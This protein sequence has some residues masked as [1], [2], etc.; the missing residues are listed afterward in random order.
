MKVFLLAGE[1]SGD[2]LGA[3]L[4]AGL[5]KHMP[6]RPE[7]YGVGGPLM[8]QAGLKTL[9]PMSDI[10]LMG[11]S[12]I[13]SKYRFLKKRIAEAADA[14]I[15]DEA[16]VLITIDLPE[17]SLRLAKAVR[18]RKQVPSVHYVAP[19]VWAW[20]PGRAQKMAPFVDHVLALFPFEPPYMQA[21]GMSC[22]FVGHPVVN[23]PCATRGEAQ[24]FRAETGIDDAPMILC[25]PGSR[26]SEI[27][28]LAP[29]F[30]KVVE[31]LHAAR[32]DLKFVLPMAASVVTLVKDQI[33][34]WPVKPFLIEPRSD[35]HAY[36]QKRAA[37]Q[38]ADVALA[39]SGTVA[40]E[41]AATQTPMVVAYDMGFLSRQ[42]IGR[43]LKVETVSLVNLIT[44]SKSIPEFIAENCREELITPSVLKVL[45]DPTGQ[46]QAMQST[47]Q[48][49]GQNGHPPGE[50]AA[51]SVIKFLAAQ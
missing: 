39:A 32:P 7:F 18:R 46:I 36:S 30:A 33:A 42:I 31:K 29:V 8:E 1:A 43:M 49:L 37:F 38:A 13:L 51:Q 44:D 41:L 35:V 25:L 28:R 16:D 45:D 2:K 27:K 11:I 21:A 24:R 47:M 22:D 12:E 17:F 4:M 48:A 14:V 34:T 20:R 23:D 3:A 10:S 15:A 50:R 9:F 5:L 26:G 40:L 6:N 19:T